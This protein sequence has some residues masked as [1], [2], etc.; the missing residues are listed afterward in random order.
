MTDGAPVLAVEDLVVALHRGDREDPVLDRVSITLGAGECLAVVG[1]SG[2][3]KTVLALAVIGLLPPGMRIAGGSIRVAGTEVVGAPEAV[4]RGLRGR[5]V[6][7]VFQDPQAS[8]HPAF[9]IGA[10][11][12][13]AIRAH[14]PEVGRSG[15][16]AE[17]AARLRAVGISD[18]RAFPHQLSGGMR[19]RVMIAM[20]T[21]NDPPCVIADE[22]TSALDVGVQAQVL[23]VLSRARIGT[24]AGLMLVTHDLGV[25]ATAADRIA[26]LYAGRLVEVGPTVAVLGDPQHP[27]T[28]GLAAAVPRLDRLAPVVPIPGQPPAV[29]DR[30]SGCAFRTRC[31]RAEDRCATEVPHLEPCGHPVPGGAGDARVACHRPGRAG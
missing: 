9:R 23:D 1:E 13:E 10:Q 25:A 7:M 22:A 16:R 31:G 11:V 4:V 14:R 12:A 6:G 2:A 28:Q 26:V 15:A 18:P 19:Q 29:G 27:Y 8:L 20:A 17:A 21:A 24:G 3:G 30:P 5:A